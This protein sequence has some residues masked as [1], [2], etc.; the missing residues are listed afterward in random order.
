MKNSV[1]YWQYSADN[2]LNKIAHAPLRLPE[3]P[4]KC[5]WCDAQTDALKM[6]RLD[7]H[8]E[9]EVCSDCL[10]YCRKCDHCG[11]FCHEDNMFINPNNDDADTVCVS[12]KET[13]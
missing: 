2:L 8:F 7:D 3:E 6:V 4:S 10:E 9:S 12:C 11:E 1:T 13:F 5:E